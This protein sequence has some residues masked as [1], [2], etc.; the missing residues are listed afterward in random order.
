MP[1]VVAQ[2]V[3]RH[4]SNSLLLAEREVHC[5]LY[6]GIITYSII[7]IYIKLS[8]TG[9]KGSSLFIVQLNKIMKYFI[10][11]YV[12]MHTYTHT[13]IYIYIYIY[14]YVCMNMDTER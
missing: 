1:V 8:A 7:Y 12:Y 11:I 14:I 3:Y 9:R 10:H 4:R 5:L 13:H 2:L 6:S